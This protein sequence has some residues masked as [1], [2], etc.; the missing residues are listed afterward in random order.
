MNFKDMSGGPLASAL[1]T[2][3]DYEKFEPNQS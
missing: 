1:S 2:A 3:T